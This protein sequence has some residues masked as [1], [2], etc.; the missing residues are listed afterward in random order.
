MQPHTHYDTFLALAGA[1]FV[2]I[3]GAL[4][5]DVDTSSECGFDSRRGHYSR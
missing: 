5:V 4:S 2:T 1:S 3:I